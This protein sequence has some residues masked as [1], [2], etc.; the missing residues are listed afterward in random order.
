MNRDWLRLTLLSMLLMLVMMAGT[1]LPGQS[2]TIWDE[3]R[4]GDLTHLDSPIQFALGLGSNVI[5]GSVQNPFDIFDP[6]GFVVASGQQL[7]SLTLLDLD[8]PAAITLFGGPVP[9]VP[10]DI[11]GVAADPAD[12]GQNLLPLMRL[13]P[14]S[15]GTYSARVFAAFDNPHYSLDLNVSPVPEPTTLLLV[16]T[17]AA[18]FGLARWRQRRREQQVGIR[19]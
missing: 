15:A 8:A 17:T 12:V 11:G 5:V 13:P 6:F 7:L 9:L 10:F 4:N 18:G 2:T 1:A 3:A 16:G 14:L 19:D